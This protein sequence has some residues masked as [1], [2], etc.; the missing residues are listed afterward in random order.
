MNTTKF[1]SV[2]RVKNLPKFHFMNS[3]GKKMKFWIANE[4]NLNTSNQSAADESDI[5]AEYCFEMEKSEN[6]FPDANSVKSKKLKAA[7][8]RLLASYDT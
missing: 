7:V 8:E 2:K 3:T 4:V 1:K 5:N 6:L